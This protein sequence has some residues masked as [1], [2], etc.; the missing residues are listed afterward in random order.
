MLRRSTQATSGGIP[1]TAAVDQIT[2]LPTRASLQE[3]TQEAITRSRPSS[4]RGV[5]AFVD[6][7]L[8]RDVND[9]Y[10]ADAGDLLLHAVGQRLSSIDL[11]G[12]RA[13]RY[14]GAQFAVVL[15]Q[16]PNL[17]AAEEVARYLMELLTPPFEV[18]GERLTISPSVG[19]A[20]STDNYP[21]VQELVN[22][23]H[24][25]V[26]QARED[27]TGYVVHDETKRGRYTTRVNESR[28]IEAIES[29]EFLLYYQP[30]VRLDTT[31][32]VGAE[33]LL[34]WN[35]PG[36]T[37]T[38]LLFPQ[39]FLGMLEKTGLGAQV[40]NWAVLEACRQLAEW[41]SVLGARATLFVTCNLGGRQ[42]AAPDFAEQVLDAVRRAGIP[43]GGLCLDI[44]EQA[45]RFN[46][47]SAWAALRDVKQA[48]VKLGLDDFGTG[49][50]SVDSLREFPL[51]LIR[52]DRTFIEG[53][54]VSG[55]DQSIVRHLTAMA[56]DLGLVTV[57]EGVETAAQATILRSLGVDLAQGYEF[58]RPQPAH[59]ILARFDRDAAEHPDH[60]DNRAVLDYEPGSG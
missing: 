22:D 39:D 24:D 38:G 51:D 59:E 3:W 32:V 33:A 49:V 19:L 7:G 9:S 43:A 37:S 48:G 15:E 55:E 50:S 27:G 58:G 5:V 46:R 34:R 14:G 57:A 44:T 56:H 53:I 45:L 16:I 60:W 23:A 29:N 42:L 6:V 13:L 4:A 35:A 8:L 2:G 25:A 10:G 41:N 40:G 11:P 54:E 20:L 12:T 26:V 18:G 28:L 1:P 31:D 47:S 36:A 30:I 52:I 21:S 17:S